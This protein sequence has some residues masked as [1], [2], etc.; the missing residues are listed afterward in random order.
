M[1]NAKI[2]LIIYYITNKRTFEEFDKWIDLLK[3]N[4]NEII[5]DIVG[6]RINL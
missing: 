4:S 5:I 3:N 2:V 6:N 1:K